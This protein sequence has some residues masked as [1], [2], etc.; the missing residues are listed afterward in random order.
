MNHMT[1]TKFL[2]DPKRLQQVADNAAKYGEKR[3]KL[4]ET[5]SLSPEDV[6]DL[7]HVADQMF[8]KDL[9]FC[10]EAIQNMMGYIEEQGIIIRNVVHA[11]DAEKLDKARHDCLEHL[12]KLADASGIKD[13]ENDPS[14]GKSRIGKTPP[15]ASSGYNF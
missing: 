15:P 10:L 12:V 4:S 2:F 8:E 3:L 1:T 6:T 7:I 14:S 5:K 9:V 13:P 11:D